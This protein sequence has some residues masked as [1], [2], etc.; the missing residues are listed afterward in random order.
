[1]LPQNWGLGGP[2]SDLDT[3]PMLRSVHFA[4]GINFGALTDC[5]NVVQ[6][7]HSSSPNPWG[8]GGL[9]VL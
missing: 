3:Q 8:P 2:C 5:D 7:G 6:G 4:S 9:V 1:M